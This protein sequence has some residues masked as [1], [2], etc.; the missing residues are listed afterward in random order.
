MQPDAI[1]SS[2]ARPQFGVVAAAQLHAA[3]LTD[4]QIRHRVAHGQ[5]ERSGRGLRRQRRCRLLRTRD[6]RGLPRRGY[7]LSCFAPVGGEA[8]RPRSPSRDTHRAERARSRPAS[9]G[10]PRSPFQRPRPRAHSRRRSVCGN[11]RLSAARRS[12][13]RGAV[14]DSLPSARA[15]D[16]QP[17]SEAH[18]CSRVSRHHSRR[19]RNGVGVLRQVLENR[20]LG[21]RISDSGLEEMA[22]L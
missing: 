9:T 6:A 1:I 11:Q 2:V 16:R 15:V 20:A 13:Q 21:D 19:G 4:R 14:V 12:R 3:G 17:T 10:R 18:S 5:L 7:R 8:A 22:K